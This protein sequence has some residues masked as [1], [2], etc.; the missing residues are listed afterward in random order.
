MYT[1]LIGSWPVAGALVLALGLGACTIPGLDNATNTAQEQISATALATSAPPT[2]VVQPVSDSQATST[3]PSQVAQQ[4]T[5][6]ALPAAT[7]QG[8]DDEELIVANV[9]ERVGPSVVRIQ[10]QGLGSGWLFDREGRYIITNNHVIEGSREVA[11]FFTGLFSTRGVVVGTDPDSDI[12][13]IQVDA[14][15]DDVQ[16]VELGDSSELRVGQRT[17]AIGNPLGQDRTVTTGIVSAL[18]R[19]IQ[20]GARFAI[21]GAIQTDAAINPG[22][23]G[24]PLLDSQGRVIGM[25]TAILSPAANPQTGAGQSSGVG[26]AVPVDLVKKVA[27]ELIAN[28]SYDHPYLGVQMGA[29]ITTLQAEQQQLPAAGV[30]IEPAPDGPLAQAGLREQAILIAVDGQEMT[31]SADVISYLE[32]ETSP[33]DTVTLSIVT[34]DGQRSELQVQ[35]GARPRSEQQ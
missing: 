2:A 25:N 3:A 35:L 10:S 34:L 5:P 24:G 13:V 7:L 16:A 21:G 1:R 12:A 4:A 26:F 32:L 30:P 29:P 20:E 11:V 8:L 17:I 9:F 15:P 31:S 6:T 18:G 19:T 33:G 28:G 23:S 27:P 14:I 22:N